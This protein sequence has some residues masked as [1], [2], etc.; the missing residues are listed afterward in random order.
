ML[1]YV[2]GSLLCILEI[3]HDIICTKQITYCNVHCTVPFT[4][5][6]TLKL[7]CT[8]CIVIYIVHCT[9]ARV[10]IW[11]KKTCFM[12]QTLVR[13]QNERLSGF[14]KSKRF[15]GKQKVVFLFG[16]NKFIFIY[17]C[18]KNSISYFYLE[19]FFFFYSTQL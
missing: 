8:L 6:F 4:S 17:L 12:I 18:I 9:L 19:S 11:V 3:T 7:Q 15:A 2:H 1:F 5:Y 13:D 10:L 16:L 14:T